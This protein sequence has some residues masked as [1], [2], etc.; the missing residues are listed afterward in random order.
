MIDRT[1]T[2]QPPNLRADRALALDERSMRLLE[3]ALAGM[4]LAAAFLLTVAR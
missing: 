4:S 1:L 3:L 2:D